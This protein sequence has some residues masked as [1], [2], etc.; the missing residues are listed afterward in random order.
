[1]ITLSDAGST[2]H[3]CLH[4]LCRPCLENADP[5][6]LG[7]VDH[8]ILPNHIFFSRFPHFLLLAQRYLDPL[9]SLWQSSSLT[10]SSQCLLTSTTVSFGNLGS[11]VPTLTYY[12]RQTDLRPWKESGGRGCLSHLSSRSS[13]G[14]PM[15]KSYLK[16]AS[17]QHL[18]L[19]CSNS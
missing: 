3:P 2:K 7:I 19:P 12:C 11:T 18:S 16:P 9:C 5:L 4:L 6:D 10:P 14:G 1:M 15:P 17:P 13:A 8:S